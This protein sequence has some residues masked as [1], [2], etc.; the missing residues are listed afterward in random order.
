MDFIPGS[1]KILLP[2]SGSGRA[3]EPTQ[4]PIK[5]VL[6]A[7]S[8]RVKQPLHET[9]ESPPFSSEAAKD[10][11]ILP[12]PHMHSLLCASAIE[13]IFLQIYLIIA[14]FDTTCVELFSAM[15]DS[16]C[17]CVCCRQQSL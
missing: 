8:P 17:N 2:C 3:L 11:T 7:P 13:H 9:D 10:G 12:L 4:H 15:G 16:V 6:G 5:L 1:G 14:R